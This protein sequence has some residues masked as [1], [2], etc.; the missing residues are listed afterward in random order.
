MVEEDKTILSKAVE[1]LGEVKDILSGGEPETPEVPEATP[2]V[3]EGGEPEVPETPE[4]K[5]PEVPE[6]TNEEEGEVQ[7]KTILKRLDT[8]EQSDLQKDR[9]IEGLEKSV[10]DKDKIIKTLTDKDETRTHKA[11]VSKALEEIK[12]I[13]KDIKDEAGL[14]KA[15][16]GKYDAD[17]LEKEPDECIKHYTEAIHI[18]KGLVPEGPIPRQ[19]HTFQPEVNDKTKI[20][21]KSLKNKLENMGV[22]NPV[23]LEDD[24]K[25]NN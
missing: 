11:I 12:P 1:K 25:E 20:K 8:L 16:E 19:G 21:I 2:E 18:A 23:P 4:V 3:P 5:E 24:E 10:E 17:K 13:N 7:M 6:P 15:M 22:E 14:L 9:K